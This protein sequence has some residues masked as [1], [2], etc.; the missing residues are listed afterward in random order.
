MPPFATWQ[1]HMHSSVLPSF[2]KRGSTFFKIFAYPT[3]TGAY[4]YTAMAETLFRPSVVER[5][6]TTALQGQGQ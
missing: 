3:T 6:P 5:L 2:V 1:K 4:A